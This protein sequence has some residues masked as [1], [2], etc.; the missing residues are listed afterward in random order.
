MHAEVTT[1]REVAGALGRRVRRRSV[2]GRI[3]QRDQQKSEG[4]FYS[5]AF[6]LRDENE[7]GC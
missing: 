7:S 6:E 4:F 1:T 2:G 5:R 3:S